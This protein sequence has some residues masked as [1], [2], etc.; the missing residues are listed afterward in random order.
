MFGGKK[1]IAYLCTA[2]NTKEGFRT[3]PELFYD[4]AALVAQTP[5]PSTIANRLEAC[6]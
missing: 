3:M 1:I 5:G 6:R 2:L 4:Y